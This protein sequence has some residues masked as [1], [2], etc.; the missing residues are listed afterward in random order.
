MISA[1][2][3]QPDWDCRQLVNNEY[4]MGDPLAITS[5]QKGIKF[6]VA[7]TTGIPR[8]NKDQQGDGSNP[9]AAL[10]RLLIIG[11]IYFFMDTRSAKALEKNVF[12]IDILCLA[13]K[14]KK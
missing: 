3:I 9:I 7:P 10:C 4:H 14:L 8:S 1:D 6:Q 11:R 2:R 5:Y 13:E 12:V